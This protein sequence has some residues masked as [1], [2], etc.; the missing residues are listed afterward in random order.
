M[1]H[2]ITTRSFYGRNASLATV[3]PGPVTAESDGNDS[4]SEAEP[5]RLELSSGSDEEYVPQK[6]VIEN[7]ESDGSDD[8]VQEDETARPTTSRGRT[9]GRSGASKNR[10]ADYSQR[11][12]ELDVVERQRE[13][14][15]F[16]SR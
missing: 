15:F 12:T 9:K 6:V 13:P 11:K 14:T 1:N 5:T 3:I 2:R 10:G 4:D 7:V 16:N 8:S